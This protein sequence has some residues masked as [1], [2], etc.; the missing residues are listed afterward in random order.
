[1]HSDSW[2]RVAEA[3]AGHRCQTPAAFVYKENL[4]SECLQPTFLDRPRS[5]HS[6]SKALQL[7]LVTLCLYV[8]L[9]VLLPNCRQRSLT[10]H[11][12]AVRYE[13]ARQPHSAP[14]RGL[15]G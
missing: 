13:A 4:L 7:I 15:S 5:A 11:R 12:S 2:Y 6:A 1:M 9:H 3:Y 14:A 10:N 8:V